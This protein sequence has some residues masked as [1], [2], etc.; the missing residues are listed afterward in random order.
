MAR[1]AACARE[2]AAACD[3]H[4]CR[5]VTVQRIVN[6]QPEPTRIVFEPTE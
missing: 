5:M 4:R 2:V 3:K 6:G 1:S